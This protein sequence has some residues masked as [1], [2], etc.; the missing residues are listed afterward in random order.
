V[1]PTLDVLVM[2]LVVQ[3]VLMQDLRVSAIRTFPIFTNLNH[4]RSIGVFRFE[5]KTQRLQS[6]ALLRPGSS[7]K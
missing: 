1:L 7:S 2:P 3:P 6:F 5:N 4:Q